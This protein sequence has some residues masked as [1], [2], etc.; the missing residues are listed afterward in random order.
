MHL[1]GQEILYSDLGML[2][3]GENQMKLDL[4][5]LQDGTYTCTMTNGTTKVTKKIVI[6]H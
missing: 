3:M 1:K 6:A 2:P 5:G 4:T